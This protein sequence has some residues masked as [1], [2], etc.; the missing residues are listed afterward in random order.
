MAQLVNK[1]QDYG[2]GFLTPTSEF[3]PLEGCLEIRDRASSRYTSQKHTPSHH[4][5]DQ[6]LPLQST[7]CM[8][9]LACATS[10]CPRMQPTKF[11][12]PSVH[13]PM[14]LLMAPS[15]FACSSWF[16]SSGKITL[17]SHC[18][19]LRKA[20]HSHCQIGSL[21]QWYLKTFLGLKKKKNDGQNISRL[22]HIHKDRSAVLF[23]NGF[24]E[25]TAKQKTNKRRHLKLF[26]NS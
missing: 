5:Q 9:L 6:M 21:S 11:K 16:T 13:L 25:Y 4:L 8:Q 7:I 3:F 12:C 17:S 24:T 19:H 23:I 20:C 22:G 18:S 15:L 10:L 14:L 1:S 26:C 2:L